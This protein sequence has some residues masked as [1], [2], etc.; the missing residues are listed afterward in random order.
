M[1]L[2]LHLDPKN[3]LLLRFP[4]HILNEQNYRPHEDHD[5]L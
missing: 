5:L 3:I 4:G 2:I 1:D